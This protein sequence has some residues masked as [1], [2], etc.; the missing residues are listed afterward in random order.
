METNGLFTV[1]AMNE[2]QNFL[3][4]KNKHKTMLFRLPK[5]KK[6]KLS[7]KD[8]ME[9]SA[10]K[11]VMAMTPIHHTTPNTNHTQVSFSPYNH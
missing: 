4:L 5:I 1:P 8:E 10:Q 3:I 7:Y 6:A 11:I 2:I 9:K